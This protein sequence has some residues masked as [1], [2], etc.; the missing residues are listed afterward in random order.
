[1]EWSL[2]AHGRRCQSFKPKKMVACHRV[3]TDCRGGKKDLGSGHILKVEASEV[4]IALN[5]RYKRR[6]TRI[7]PK[8]GLSN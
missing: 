8:F 3:E 7:S 6:D 5:L 4:L 2:W 1:M